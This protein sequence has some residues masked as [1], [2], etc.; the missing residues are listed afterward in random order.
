ML[1]REDEQMI[2][3]VDFDNTLAYTEYPLIIAPIYPM[4]TFVKQARLGGH[5]IILNT[6]RQGKSLEEALE[7]CKSHGL[8]FDA[9]NENLKERIDE[10]GG[11]CRKISADYYIDDLNLHPAHLLHGLNLC[12]EWIIKLRKQKNTEVKS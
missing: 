9:V 8:E 7:W 2:F 5:K 4:I 1:E 3:A 12:Q 11:D 10:Y 6:C